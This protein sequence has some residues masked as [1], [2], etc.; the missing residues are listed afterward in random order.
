[1]E[2]DKSI[3]VSEDESMPRQHR[4]KYAHMR[5]SFCDHMQKFWVTKIIFFSFRIL[6]TKEMVI[7]GLTGFGK[8]PSLTSVDFEEKG[9]GVITNED[10]AKKEFV[11]EYKYAICYPRSER[12]T[13]E[14]EYC[15]TREGCFILEVNLPNNK[16][17]CLDATRAIYTIGRLINHQPSHKANLRLHPPIFLNNKWRVGLY[18]ARD[19]KAGEELSYDYGRQPDPPDFMRLRKVSSRKQ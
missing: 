1:M 5:H 10:I 9:R 8:R 3:T 11:C 14:E 17:L 16:W 15:N 13:H 4:T 12:Q 7:A 2:E 19:I 6:T 18:A